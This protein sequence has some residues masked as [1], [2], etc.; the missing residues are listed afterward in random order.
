M[1]TGYRVIRF[2]TTN[3]DNESSHMK[4]RLSES[5]R[6]ALLALNEGGPTYLNNVVTKTGLTRSRALTTLEK[7]Q[8]KSLVTEGLD[9]RTSFNYFLPTDTGANVISALKG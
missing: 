6:K 2:E 9:D 8:V 4:I 1:T 7:L 3:P 5:E